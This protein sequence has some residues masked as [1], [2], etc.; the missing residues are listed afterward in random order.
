MN[1]L[2][3][4]LWFGF[5][6]TVLGATLGGCLFWQL[7]AER[8]ISYCELDQ[9]VVY[10]VRSGDRLYVKVGDV[11]TDSGQLEI[12]DIS[13]PFD[14]EEAQAGDM[15]DSP[16]VGFDRLFAYNGLVVTMGGPLITVIDPALPSGGQFVNE[17]DMHD[18][19]DNMMRYAVY[20]DYYI[21]MVNSD[22]GLELT[23]NVYSMSDIV[24]S[25]SPAPIST[26][27]IPGSTLAAGTAAAVHGTVLYLA[28]PPTFHVIDLSNVN[29]PTEMATCPLPDLA[30]TGNALA[31]QGRYAYIL[32]SPSAQTIVYGTEGDTDPGDAVIVDV[33][34]STAPR[35]VT[36]IE[37]VG[38]PCAVSGSYLLAR[39]GK[40]I[41]VYDLSDIAD[42]K[43]LKPLNVRLSATAIHVDGDYALVPE[44]E[45][46]QRKGVATVLIAPYR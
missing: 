16:P 18:M 12:L 22:P 25:P 14:V 34:S 15:V 4:M 43:Y 1:R 31:I 7:T 35:V 37:G 23:V 36:S 10:S 11:G 28:S 20:G 45:P 19:P 26:L 21:R 32:P 46:Q 9:S 39:S 33:G 38:G 17:L 24:G 27:T 13:N 42:P 29:T 2:S 8:L 3:K 5:L 44:A 6:A 30:R 41:D 40:S